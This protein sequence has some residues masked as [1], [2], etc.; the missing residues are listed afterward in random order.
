[1]RPRG[2]DGFTVIELLI[3]IVVLTV[4]VGAM[5][6][7]FSVSLRTTSETQTRLDGSHNAQITGAYFVKDVQSADIVE[8]GSTACGSGSSLASIAWDDLGTAK[9]ATYRYRTSD[10][11]LVRTFCAAGE[12]NAEV[13]LGNPLPSAPTVTCDIAACGVGTRRVDLI[14]TSKGGYQFKLTGTRRTS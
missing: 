10:K 6:G 2:G 5:G 12:A 7:V 11:R 4:L 9:R 14:V 3:A 13:A 1:M 8:L